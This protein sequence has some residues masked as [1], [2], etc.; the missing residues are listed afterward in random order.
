[1]MA[2]SP[3][4]IERYKRHILLKEMGGQGQ[5]KLLETKVLIVGAGGLGSPI[6]LYL[7]AAGIGTIG[8]CDDDMVALSNLQR[9]ILY[10][11]DHI[12]RSKAQTARSHIRQLNPELTVH[13]HQERIDSKN[14]HK[15]IE[16]YDI[17]VEGVDNFD[18]RFTLNKACLEQQKTFISAAVGRFEGQIATFKPWQ[19]SPTGEA[20]PCYRCFVPDAPP[21]DE[22]INCEEEGILGAITGVVGSL[23]AMEVLKEAA[24][25]GASLAGRLLI[26]DGLEATT[27]LITL[28]SDPACTDCK[29]CSPLKKHE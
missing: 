8:I 12:G 27:R 19:K 6:I 20:L 25:L 4:Q 7:A 9:Q 17:I 18:T 2:L 21:R 22:Q 23:A 26:Y 3:K 5:Q 1:M 24:N 10:T 15:I 16:N 29:A 11:T 14:A 28:K 13:L